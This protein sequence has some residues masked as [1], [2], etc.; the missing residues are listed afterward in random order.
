M[1]ERRII[2]TLLSDHTKWHT[3]VIEDYARPIKVHWNNFICPICEEVADELEHGKLFVC[4]VCES[5]F[6]AYGNSLRIILVPDVKP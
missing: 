2:E 3:E 6:L 1:S 5:E 4:G